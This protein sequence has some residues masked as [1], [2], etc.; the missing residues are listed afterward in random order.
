MARPDQTTQL[1]S[2]PVVVQPFADASK[3][4]FNRLRS[5]LSDLI[6]SAG[7]D[8]MQPQEVSRRFSVNRNLAW[9]VSKIIKE[10][11]PGVAVGHLPGDAGF[12]ILVGSLTKAGGSAEAASRVRAS[13]I[14]LHHLIEVHAGDRA[15][16]ETMLTSSSA[17]DDRA[18]QR[19]ESQRKQAFEGA[20]T[21]WGVQARLQFNTSF[22]APGSRDGMLDYAWVSGFSHFCRLRSNVSWPIAMQRA[23]RDD[24][25]PHASARP[26]PF[27]AGHEMEIPII[28]RFT[29][30][31]V[32]EIR[33]VRTTDHTVY[34][35]LREGP[36]GK[37]AEI[38]CVLGGYTCND[39]GMYKSEEDRL[40]QHL[41]HP[42]TPVELFVQDVFVHKIMRSSMPPQ[43]AMY[44]NLPGGARYPS[45]GLTHGQLPLAATVQDLG[46]GP[47][48]ANLLEYPAYR[49][50]IAYVFESR[51][52]DASD[53][54]AYRL[55]LP[56]PPIPT[57]MVMRYELLDR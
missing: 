29:S 23:I 27:D 19:Y 39:V 12:E 53:F 26:T 22:I 11:E 30:D 34:Y 8:P 56:Y 21:T 14:E 24:G 28:R 51:G 37:K 16:L 9:K 13:V 49:D 15:T 1:A 38:D 36:V 33:E 42:Q 54:H 57:T 6:I 55:R 47:P 43:A 41:V 44:S 46:G 32:P 50:L 45:A 35:E 2:Q 10:P 48:M 52:W 3:L 4:V 31:P 40:G 7:G 5:A 25:T 20:R 18:M 17:G